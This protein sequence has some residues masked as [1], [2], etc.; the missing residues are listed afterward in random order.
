MGKNV[1]YHNGKLGSIIK[2][3]L[4]IVKKDYTLVDDYERLRSNMYLAIPELV[5]KTKC[6]NCGASMEEVTLE[7]DIHDAELLI[8]MAGDVKYNMDARGLTFSQA[9]QIH[10][11][12][13]LISTLIKSRATKASKLGL[14]AEL[15]SSNGKRIP[16]VWVIT[17]RGWEGLRGERIPSKIKMWRDSIEKRF[18]DT[19]S[20]TDF[21]INGYDP[22]E[23]IGIGD[24]PVDYVDNV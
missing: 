12:E 9:N 7:L 23:W 21:K 10:V 24:K 8:S 19:V 13:L 2:V 5:D 17:R 4:S 22:K 15:R 6:I 3:L 1:E 14:I 20:F 16:G 11:S 18:D